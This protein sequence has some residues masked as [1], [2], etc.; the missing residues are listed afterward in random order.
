M[1]GGSKLQEGFWM[2]PIV[3]VSGMATTSRMWAESQNAIIPHVDS[4]TL[5]L[6]DCVWQRIWLAEPFLN[7]K[8]MSGKNADDLLLTVDAKHALKTLCEI[9]CMNL[10]C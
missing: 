7:S 1:R 4:K 5:A 6:I 8:E 9:N 2:A 3:G 10:T